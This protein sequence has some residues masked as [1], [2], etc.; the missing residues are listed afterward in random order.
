MFTSITL[1]K[2][3]VNSTFKL[4]L[5]NLSTA[6]GDHALKRTHLYS[7][8]KEELKAKMVPFAGYEMPVQYP[9]GVMKE[10]L[11]CR[12]AVGLFDV[13]HMG[14]LRIEGKDAAEFL[15]YITVADV[16]ALQKGSATLSLITNEKGGI[17]DDTII[18]KVENDKFFV[19]VNGACK[20][21]DLA[22]MMDIKNSSKFDRKD[23]SIKLIDDHSLIAI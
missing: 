21:K 11:H 18:T 22:H 8:H 6:T 9:E 3:L 19:V 16:Q 1:H 7:Y 13:S 20:D 14:Q 15:E 10:H 5:R 23:I 17:K 12:E 2:N 4:A